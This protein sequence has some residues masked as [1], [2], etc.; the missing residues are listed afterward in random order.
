[1]NYHY[2]NGFDQKDIPLSEKYRKWGLFLLEQGDSEGALVYFSK[3]KA[4]QEPIEVRLNLKPLYL[5]G[6][7]LTET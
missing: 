5:N 6:K 1:M 2:K 7:Q 3:I 4:A